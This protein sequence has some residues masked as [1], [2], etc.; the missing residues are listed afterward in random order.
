[1]AKFPTFLELESLPPYL[2]KPVIGPYSERVQ[3]SE[4][5]YTL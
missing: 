1:V 3:F 2:Q 4:H 5:P